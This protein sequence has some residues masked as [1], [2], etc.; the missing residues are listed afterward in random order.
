MSDIVN[1]GDAQISLEELAGV[2]M[3]GV[4][5]YRFSIVPVGVYTFKGVEA[6]LTAIDT[7]EGKKAVVQFTA[8]ITSVLSTTDANADGLIGKKHTE[9]FFLSKDLQKGLGAAK[10]FMTDIGMTG[11]GTLNELLQQFTGHEFGAA[12]K[13]RKDKNDPDRIYAGMNK[14]QT[15]DEMA[16]LRG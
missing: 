3:S 1:V 13:H 16:G 15:M 5:E 8:E 9:S 14:M 4:E 11:N 12:I 2:D 6:A 10:A 7:N